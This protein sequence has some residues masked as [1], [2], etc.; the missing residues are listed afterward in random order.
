MEGKTF[1]RHFTIIFDTFSEMETFTPFFCRAI[2]GSRPS[3][4]RGGGLSHS[5]TCGNGFS[6]VFNSSHSY[7][8]SSHNSGGGSRGSHAGSNGSGGSRPQF[9]LGADEPEI[10]VAA[11][12]RDTPLREEDEEGEEEIVNQMRTEVMRR[13]RF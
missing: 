1:D 13:R 5:M 10:M 11:D 8:N 6:S 4:S 12:S 3:T 2:P 7:Y 9:A